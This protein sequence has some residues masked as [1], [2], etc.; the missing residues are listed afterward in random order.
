L[1]LSPIEAVWSFVEH[2]NFR[3]A[4]SATLDRFRRS[5][6][7]TL[8]LEFLRELRELRVL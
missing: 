1:K 8:T 5:R 2:A 7:I 3:I 6:D 4:I